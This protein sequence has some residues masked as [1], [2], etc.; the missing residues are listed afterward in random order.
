MTPKLRFGPD[1]VFDP[2]DDYTRLT[3][4]TIALSSMS[5]RFNSFYEP[6][7][8]PF[9]KDMVDV[10]SESSNRA[11]RGPLAR[12]LPILTRRADDAYFEKI[13]EMK[14]VAAESESC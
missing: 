8:P 13:A 2:S 7:M 5:H 9:T 1:N 6:D 10:L 11:F 12:L 4:D 14:R 3:F